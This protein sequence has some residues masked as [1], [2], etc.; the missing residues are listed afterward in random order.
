MRRVLVIE[1]NLTI[2]CL[3]Q[4]IIQQMGFATTT[5]ENGKDGVQRAIVE[6]PDLILM[7]VIMPEMDGREAMR[8]LR[9]HPN[10]KEI[11]VITTTALSQ[12]AVLKSC[13]DAGSNDHIVKP[14]TTEELLRKIKALIR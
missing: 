9:A 4:A 10:T 8:I 14:F 5:A 7:D 11:P 13:I 6:K 3:L 12:G 1:D 2:R